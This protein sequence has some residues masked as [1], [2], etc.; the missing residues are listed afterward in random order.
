MDYFDIPKVMLKVTDSWQ[1]R[2][3]KETQDLREVLPN[4]R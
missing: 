2:I 4:T 1:I 3:N